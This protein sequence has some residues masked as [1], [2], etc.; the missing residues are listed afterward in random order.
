MIF[1]S[2]TFYND[3]RTQ[4]LSIDP[5]DKTTFRTYINDDNVIIVQITGYQ[6]NLYNEPD[7]VA[8]DIQFDFNTTDQQDALIRD[9]ALDYAKKIE[10]LYHVDD[11]LRRAEMSEKEYYDQ[12]AYMRGFS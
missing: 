9:A 10:E 12:L 2:Y 1:D 5:I 8:V 11:K 3:N 4:S 6:P 7:L